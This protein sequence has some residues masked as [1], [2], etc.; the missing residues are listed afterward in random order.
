MKELLGPLD[1]KGGDKQTSA[2][3]VGRQ[4]LAL[5]CRATTGFGDALPLAVA[6]GVL[7]FWMARPL[8]VDGTRLHEAAPFTVAGDARM[9]AAASGGGG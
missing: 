5:Q 9:P 7:G 3:L 6:V 4:N 2:R 8:F 1:R